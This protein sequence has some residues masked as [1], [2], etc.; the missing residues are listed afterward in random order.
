MNLDSF[1][2]AAME[3]AAAILREIEALAGALWGQLDARQI[4]VLRTAIA[5]AAEHGI[6]AWIDKDGRAG[7]M[8]NV[9]HALNIMES[10]SAIAQLRASGIIK[11]AARRALFGAARGAIGL[12]T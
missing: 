3:I 8:R 11:E 7:H 5:A 12:L 4:D 10:E 2:P 1:K 9:Q 6:L